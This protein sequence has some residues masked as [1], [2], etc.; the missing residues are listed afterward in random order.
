MHIAIITPITIL[1]CASQISSIS[2]FNTHFGK[3]IK[4]A[5]GYASNGKSG[6]LT[7][8]LSGYTRNRMVDN[9]I[10]IIQ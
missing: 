4:N 6:K 1:S 3:F 8:Q 5:K 10:G 2:L 9:D 7:L